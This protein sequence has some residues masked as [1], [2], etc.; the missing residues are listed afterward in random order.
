MK[1]FMDEIVN[2]DAPRTWKIGN[3]DNM[4]TALGIQNLSQFKG[5]ISEKELATA[6]QNAG[7]IQEVK[8]L[9]NAIM[10]RSINNTVRTTSEHM[11]DARGLDTLLASTTA[12]RTSLATGTGGR[13][14]SDPTAFGFDMG[15]E[16]EMVDGELTG[17]TGIYGMQRQTD[18]AMQDWIDQAVGGGGGDV[19]LAPPGSGVG[20]DQMSRDKDAFARGQ[21]VAGRR[22]GF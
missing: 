13:F 21:V 11:E 3:V 16:G 18:A 7:S 12:A 19:D 6:M 8:G 1:K 5:A 17:A 4:L 14:W 15:S 22:P 20:D 2:P 9:L 10:S